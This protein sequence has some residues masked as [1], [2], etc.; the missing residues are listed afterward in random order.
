MTLI[1]VDKETKKVTIDGDV[2]ITGSINGGLNALEKIVAGK[3]DKL[4]FDSTPTAGSSNPVT[5]EGI[6]TAIDNIDVSISLIR[7]TE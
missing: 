5:S 1:N 3:Q 4:T 7:W 6:K 2:E